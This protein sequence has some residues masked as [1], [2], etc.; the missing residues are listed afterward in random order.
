MTLTSFDLYWEL[1]QSCSTRFR[2]KLVFVPPDRHLAARTKAA[3]AK[4]QKDCRS[5]REARVFI[6]QLGLALA[7]VRARFPRELGEAGDPSAADPQ[8]APSN[9]RLAPEAGSSE[10]PCWDGQ[11][12]V[13]RL[14]ERV[15]KRFRQP[16]PN[17]EAV[18]S[19]F[20]QED[21]PPRIDDPLPFSIDQDAKRRLNRTIERLNK[22]QRSSLIRFYGDGTGRAVCWEPLGAVALKLRRA[23]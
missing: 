2:G 15:V 16:S 6:E 5:A 7:D 8:S 13:L 20:Q 10:L 17:Q 19:A 9:L 12:R 11:L 22:H 23:A 14:G 18:L 4:F 3:L 1:S 21:W